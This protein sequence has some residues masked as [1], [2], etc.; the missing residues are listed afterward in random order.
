MEYEGTRTYKFKVDSIE[1]LLI[2]VNQ[3]A[4][5]V[6]RFIFLQSSAERLFGFG[7]FL[8]SYLCRGT[9]WIVFLQLVV[10]QGS[11]LRISLFVH[12]G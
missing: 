12:L 5:S 6:V 3:S 11:L 2:S 9:V 7:K 10:N 4:L 1:L 8:P